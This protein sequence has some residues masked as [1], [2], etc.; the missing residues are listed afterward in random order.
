M[1]KVFISGPITGT[2]DFIDRFDEADTKLS[3]MDCDVINPLN[4]TSYLP[5]GTAWSTYM[6]ATLAGLERADAI[7]S[8]KGWQDSFGA[9]IERIWAEKLGLILMEESNAD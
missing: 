3:A 5:Q 7:Y 8:L 4:I 2:E 1:I 9:R 6:R